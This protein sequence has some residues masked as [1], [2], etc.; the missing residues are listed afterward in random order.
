AF[1]ENTEAAFSGRFSRSTR[2][3]LGQQHSL[4]GPVVLH[5]RFAVHLRGAVRARRRAPAHGHAA[6]RV[7]DHATGAVL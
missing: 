4:A 2:P 5:W 7:R 6:G 1:T 3:W